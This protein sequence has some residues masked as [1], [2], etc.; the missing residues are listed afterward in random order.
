[1]SSFQS[2][3]HLIC[4][5]TALFK[6][7]PLSVMTLC[8][9]PSLWRA[10][11]FLFW[12]KS[13]VFLIIVVSKNKRFY[14]VGM[15]INWNSN[16]NI[17]IFWDTDFWLSW[18]VSSN[19]QNEN[20]TLLK[21]FTLHLRNLKYMKVSLFEMLQEKTKCSWYSNLFRCT[22]IFVY[23]KHFVNCITFHQ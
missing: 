11:M 17:I 9:L 20:K 5:D 10:S 2:T 18:A 14:T 4:F 23:Y 8:D 1:M 19:N 6:Q 21:C 16:I 3:L 7:P 15:L 12:I 13:A 22:C